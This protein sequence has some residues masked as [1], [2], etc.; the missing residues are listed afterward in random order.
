MPC[1]RQLEMLVDPS[2]ETAQP[3]VVCWVERVHGTR[4]DCATMAKIRVLNDRLINKIAAGEVVE[5]PASVLKELLENSL[6]AGATE[7]RIDV[8]AGGK[9][10]LRVI[11]DGEGMDADDVLLALERHAT[12]KIS[13]FGDLEN[14]ATLGFRGEALPSIAAVSRMVLRS[15]PA[16][17]VEGN[18]AV[19]EGGVIKHFRPCAMA[20]GTLVEVRSLF[21]NVP[22]RRKFMRSTQTEYAH[23]QNIASHYAL[24]FPEINLVLRHDGSEQINATPTDSVRERISQVLGAGLLARLIALE[25]SEGDTR[26]VGFV[27]EPSLHRANTSMMHFYVNRRAVRD[28]VLIHAVRSAYEDLLPGKRAP[29]AFLF[30]ELPAA[31]VDVNVH[32]SKT[33]IRFRRPQFVHELVV[34]AVRSALSRT[35]PLT[36]LQKERAAKAKAVER[37]AAG[38]PSSTLESLEKALKRAG[39][40]KAPT[41][42]FRELKTVAP[43]GRQTA[44]PRST[45]EPVE[46]DKDQ[47]AVA[48]PEVRKEEEVT[49]QPQERFLGRE[50]DPATI[51]PLGQVKNSYIIASFRGGMLIIDQHAAHERILYEQLLKAAKE[52]PESQGLLH[53]QVINLNPVQA[54]LLEEH[55]GLLGSL[56]FDVEPFGMGSIVLRSLPAAFDTRDAEEIL[57]GIAADLERLGKAPRDALV[58]EL[59]LSASCQGA[60]KINTPLS[61]EKM[62]WLLDELFRCEM[63][64]RCPHGRPVVLT[65]GEEDLRRRFGRS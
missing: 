52:T 29:A 14:V 65:F 47:E 13:D 43:L 40:R 59:I 42:D 36:P 53:P 7:L 21:F 41:I 18:E 63:P 11:D 23:C 57:T 1:I 5:R 56:G 3:I 20:P 55:S 25:A 62:V 12:S 64:M 22:A 19:V 9:R 26:L 28:K 60:I 10:L 2:A 8:E 54:R 27:S 61:R 49:T 31:Q 4:Y 15:H 45:P 24:A 48:T 32:P 30:L 16:R 38:S 50:I 35:Q 51:S 39:D 46:A 58:R 17:Q 44:A 37:E 34:S 6:D 33:E